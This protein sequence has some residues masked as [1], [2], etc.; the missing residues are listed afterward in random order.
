MTSF[1]AVNITAANV[2]VWFI[3]PDIVRVQYSPDGEFRSNN[4]GVCVAH[5]LTDFPLQISEGIGYRSIVSDSL[6]VRVNSLGA[7]SFYDR[8]GRLLLA[9]DAACPHRAERRWIENV[10]YK[11]GSGEVIHTANGDVQQMKEERRDTIGSTWRC[12]L[13]FQW[14]QGEAL[15]GPRFTHGGLHEPSWQASLP[16]SAQ[17]Q[18]D[19]AGHQFHRWLRTARRCRMCHAV[20]RRYRAWLHA[21]CSIRD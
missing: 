20:L 10:T 5:A 1:V 3:T 13:N 2:R 12:Y 7:V 6:E 18:G 11:E 21:R 9:E 19:G 14:Q 15:Y 17:P 4:T 8:N 16:L